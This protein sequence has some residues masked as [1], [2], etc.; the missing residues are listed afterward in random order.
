MARLFDQ[1]EHLLER[2]LETPGRLLFRTRL[3]PVE[4]ARA[5]GR[6][7]ESSGLVGPDGLLVPNS[8]RVELHPVDFEPFAPWLHGLQQ[9]LARFVGQRAAGRGWVCAGKPIVQ[10]VSV[11]TAARGRPFVVAATVDTTDSGGSASS[12]AAT[13]ALERTAVLTP[14]SAPPP[15][16]GPGRASGGWLELHN[17]RKVHLRPSVTRLGRAPDNDVVL[18][19]PSV[20]R[21]HAQIK[22]VGG[23]YRLVDLAS[24][25][26]TRVGT[27]PVGQQILRSGQTIY[28]GALPIRFFTT[29]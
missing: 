16:S 18:A 26:G 7:M 23:E 10:V 11:P 5:I 19:D 6:A 29:P 14:Q 1:V 24:H 4:L 9:D 21:Y 2:V 8:Y 3:E 13:S 15:A 17:G 12:G 22:L 28:L 27:V 20:S 25:N